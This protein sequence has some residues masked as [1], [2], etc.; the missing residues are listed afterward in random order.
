MP[1]VEEGVVLP[2]M[3]LEV[4]EYMA[5]CF[6]T[7][8][9]G[10]EIRGDPFYQRAEGKP[11]LTDDDV[12]RVIAAIDSEYAFEIGTYPGY[13]RNRSGSTAVADF[14]R[15]SQ[16]SKRAMVE[17]LDAIIARHKAEEAEA[18]DGNGGC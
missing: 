15:L 3:V 18:K 8:E 5:T 14:S 16:H 12:N 1:I 17:G 6:D 13:H 10:E 4:I 11:F 7:M 2:D 9:A